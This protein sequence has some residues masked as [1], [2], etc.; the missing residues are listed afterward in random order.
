MSGE[1]GVV[2]RGFLFDVNRC[3]GC[4][5]C[6]LA[7]S[8]ENELGW[9]R[10]WRQVVPFNE[11]RRPGIP[12]FHLSLACNHCEEAPCMGQCPALAIG[13]EPSTGAVLIDA[14]RCIGCGYCSWVCPYDALRFD[15]DLSVMTKCTSCNHRLKEGLQRMACPSVGRPVN[16]PAGETNHRIRL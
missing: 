7:C 12:T 10:S 13:R 8:T 14:D 11:E 3:T 1:E 15:D 9:G 16:R 6:E 2:T 5:A 4:H